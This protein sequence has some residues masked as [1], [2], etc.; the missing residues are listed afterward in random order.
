MKKTII[1]NFQNC[2]EIIYA[3]VYLSAWVLH[4]IARILLAI[5][6]AGLL[7]GRV[8]QDIIKSLFKWREKY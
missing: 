7:N 8:A 1:R 3:P 2:V 5:A 6:Y 4:K